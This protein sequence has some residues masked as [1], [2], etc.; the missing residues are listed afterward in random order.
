MKMDK[1]HMLIVDIK[2]EYLKHADHLDTFYGEEVSVREQQIYLSGA[3]KALEDL[4]HK[5][6]M[7]EHGEKNEN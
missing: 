1:V 5:L 4:S 3:F 2:E 6:T 7:M